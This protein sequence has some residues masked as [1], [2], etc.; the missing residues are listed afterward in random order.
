[1]KISITKEEEHF[2]NFVIDIPKEKYLMQ[3]LKNQAQCQ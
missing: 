2:Q 1:M 3:L